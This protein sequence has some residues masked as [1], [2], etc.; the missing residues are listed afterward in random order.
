MFCQCQGWKHSRLR[1]IFIQIFLTCKLKR[2]KNGEVHVASRI[3]ASGIFGDHLTADL[4][5]LRAKC[6]RH[7]VE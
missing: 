7:K 3:S 2:V 6:P 4:V 1:Q 5:T